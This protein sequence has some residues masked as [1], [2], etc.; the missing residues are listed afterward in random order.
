MTELLPPPRVE[1]KEEEKNVDPVQDD[2]L[3]PQPPQV[4]EA[5]LLDH[6]FPYP[7]ERE[8]LDQPKKE[9]TQVLD[10]PKID[11]WRKPSE[12]PLKDDLPRVGILH[13]RKSNGETGRDSRWTHG[14]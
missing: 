14:K 13:Y 3:N 9:Q 10:Q 6:G 5:K 11:R 12:R 4:E 1:R 2:P 8:L 7:K